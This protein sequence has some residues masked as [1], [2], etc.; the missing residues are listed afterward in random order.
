MYLACL[1]FLLA[2]FLSLKKA[3]L[4]G[5]PQEEAGSRSP[6]LEGGHPVW[7]MGRCVVMETCSENQNERTRQDKENKWLFPAIAISIS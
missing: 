7:H 4:I 5:I 2:L 1:Y 3:S 6:R